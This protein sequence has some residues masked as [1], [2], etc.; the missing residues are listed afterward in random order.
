MSSKKIE[1]LTSQI[2][3]AYKQADMKKMKVPQ[4]EQMYLQNFKLFPVEILEKAEWNYKEEDEFMSQQL[5][6]NIKRIGLVENLQVRKLETGYYQVING[7]HRYD[8][9]IALGKRF[10]ICYDHGDISLAEA[11]RRAIET[12]ETK[13]ESNEIKLSR[14]LV[15]INAEE[16]EDL[17]NTLPYTDKQIEDAE[18]LINLNPEDI[19]GGKPTTVT[20]TEL[21]G[22]VRDGIVIYNVK[23]PEEFSK[24]FE[25]YIE[26]NQEALNIKIQ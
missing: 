8:E 17:E 26:N 18:K 5:R 3:R 12:N 15:D 22:I 9:M 7:N 24:E 11:M 6:N 19:G 1:E 10:V 2:K 13:F 20:K 21:G 4:R 25:K 16:L 14:H 23:V